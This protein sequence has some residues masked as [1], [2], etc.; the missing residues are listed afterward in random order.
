[1][2]NGDS[3]TC[4]NVNVFFGYRSYSSFEPFSG[5]AAVYFLFKDAATGIPL[6]TFVCGLNQSGQIETFWDKGNSPTD[7]TFLIHDTRNLRMVSDDEGVISKSV[8]LDFFLD[9]K[10]PVCLL[11]VQEALQLLERLRRGD[12]EEFML[13]NRGAKIR[14]DLKEMAKTIVDAHN[15]AK[16]VAFLNGDFSISF[17]I[18]VKTSSLH[19]GNGIFVAL[20]DELLERLVEDSTHDASPLLK[21]VTAKGR[22]FIGTL[23]NEHGTGIEYKDGVSLS[24]VNAL[25]FDGFD[26]FNE[27]T[28]DNA[29][30]QK[31]DAG[32]PSRSFVGTSVVVV[33][34]IFGC[35][36]K[37]KYEVLGE[38]SRNGKRYFLLDGDDGIQRW[39]S[40]L[41]AS[42]P[43]L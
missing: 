41:N 27:G 37:E 42:S 22:K 12:C 20:N 30:E 24:Y 2:N 6:E 3:T 17:P 10:Y 28:N 25:G 33:N 16:M 38:I 34:D 32:M 35:F 18:D 43:K 4:V 8:I 5:K 7:I 36:G 31:K 11:F 39:I 23:A 9:M 13:R 19:V 26:L 29:K 1:M 40:D 15:K 21:S 14:L